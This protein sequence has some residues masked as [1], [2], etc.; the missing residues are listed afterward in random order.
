[1]K[2]VAKHLLIWVFWYGSTNISAIIKYKQTP[3]VPAFYN[4]ISLAVVFYA[5]YY[6]AKSYAKKISLAEGLIKIK[7]GNFKY[8]FFRWEV[9]GFLGVLFGNI[10]IS[11]IIDHLLFGQKLSFYLSEDFWMYADGKFARQSLYVYT[12][13]AI[14]F[15]RQII[16]Y[17]NEIITYKAERLKVE[18]LDNRYLRKA[19]DERYKKLEKYI[20]D[21]L[22]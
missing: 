11:W 22:S 15:V 1:M 14:A 10:F 16:K 2:R 13:I 7:K 9:A 8:F 20:H 21:H 17:K 19:L 6:L 4:F 5:C 12:G 3:W 18:Q